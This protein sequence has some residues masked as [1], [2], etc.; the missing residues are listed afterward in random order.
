MTRAEKERRILLSIHTANSSFNIW[1]HSSDLKHDTSDFEAS[2]TGMTMSF[3][4]FCVVQM[5]DRN[6]HA[7]DDVSWLSGKCNPK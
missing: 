6:G 1:I 3:T 4:I 5:T 7:P 2:L